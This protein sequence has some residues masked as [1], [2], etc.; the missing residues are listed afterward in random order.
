MSYSTGV[1]NTISDIR[2]TVI[3]ACVAAGWT[4]N[5]TNEVLH[6]GSMFNKL[7]MTTKELFV[8]GRRSLTSGDAPNVVGIGLLVNIAGE[9]TYEIEF[10]A[11]YHLFI[12]DEEVYCVINYAVNIYQWF[13]FGKSSIQGLPGSGNWV[14]GFRGDSTPNLNYGGGVSWPLD[15][16]L[17]T[18]GTLAFGNGAAHCPVIFG[19]PAFRN[20]Y[21]YYNYSCGRSY[22]VD[23]GLDGEGWWMLSG[24]PYGTSEND[25]SNPGLY[26]AWPDIQLTPSSWNS[27]GVLIPIR[28]FKNRP[29]NRVSLV[30]ELTNARHLR[31]DNYEERQIITLG[32]DQW[33]VFPCYKRDVVARN[34]GKTHTGTL[35][36]AI[37]YEV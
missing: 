22:F 31:I 10:P 8:T 29:S 21:F 3:N 35:G 26:S 9:P 2:S 17:S 4:W 37:K 27:E 23:S 32:M 11:T 12:F 5:A 28:A 7:T 30:A 36:F 13:C 34:G 19:S 20:Y 1:V 25:Y 16:N 15:V 24:K 14:A 18:Y 33:M 6:K